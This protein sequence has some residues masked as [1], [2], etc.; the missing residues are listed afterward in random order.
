MEIVNCLY[1]EDGKIEGERYKRWLE[2][3]WD[4]LYL[5]CPIKID[6]IEAV[7]VL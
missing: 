6:L 3:A 4:R 7:K 2:K 5:V 1:Y